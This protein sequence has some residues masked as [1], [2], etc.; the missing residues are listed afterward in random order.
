MSIYLN[1]KNPEKHKPFDDAS[2]DIVE[3]VRYLE[4]IAGKSPHTAFNYYCDLRNFSRFMKR[5]RAL[6]PEDAEIKEIDPKGLDTTF[7][8]SVTKEDIYEYLYFLNRECGNKKSSTAR[9]LASLHGFYDY[10]VNQVNK[11]T[12]DPTAA[13]RPPKQDKVLPKYLTAEQSMDLL[14]STQTQSD[15]PERDYCMTVLFLNCGR[16]CRDGSG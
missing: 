3:Y 9:R 1:E 14:E 7:W 8:A 5:R 6:V 2:Q 10:L 11:I 15:F 16:A 4:V 12:Q 13:I